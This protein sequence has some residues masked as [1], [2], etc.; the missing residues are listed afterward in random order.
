MKCK[1][2]ARDFF[3]KLDAEINKIPTNEEI[4]TLEKRKEYFSSF[5]IHMSF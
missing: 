2:M 4:D 5:F 1:K 3:N